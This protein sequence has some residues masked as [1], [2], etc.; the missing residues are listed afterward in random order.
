MKTK[1][2]L[3]AATALLLGACGASDGTTFTM[4]SGYYTGSDSHAVAGVTDECNM[5]ASYVG[6]FDVPWGVASDGKSATI[7]LTATD[8]LAHTMQ[9][10]IDGNGL[11]STKTATYSKV[12]A[13]SGDGT[14]C[15]YNVTTT[16]QSGELVDNNVVHLVLKFD[17]V[18]A[19]A[20]ICSA[21]ELDATKAGSCSSRID[22][23]ATKAP[24]V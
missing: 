18:E 13:D 12:L 9:V 20:G 5:V 3:L 4:T 15:T 16:I 2:L 14:I 19:A 1:N 22:F 10:A 23:L 8:D 21:A 6:L 17:A 7:N 24:N 11:T